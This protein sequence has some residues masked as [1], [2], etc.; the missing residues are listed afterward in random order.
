MHSFRLQGAGIPRGVT[1][2]AHG[3]LA[4]TDHFVARM[5]DCM[6]TVAGDTTRKT[7]RGERVLVRAGLEQL[8]LEDVAIRADIGDVGDPWG[9]RSV[10]AMARGAGGRTQVA[11]YHHSLMVHTL[12]VICELVCL[13]AVRLHVIGIG[14][15]TR[16][17][18]CDVDR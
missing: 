18:G 1:L 17:R 14:M 8:R 10:V 13:D 2:H 6:I 5:L 3:F 11:S 9:C 12:L 7:H 15:T 4:G 16:A